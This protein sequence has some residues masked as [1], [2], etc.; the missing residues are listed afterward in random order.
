MS[1]DTLFRDM[2]EKHADGILVVDRRG[3][4]RSANPAAQALLGRAERD[5]LGQPFGYPLAPG[6]AEI[7]I[8]AEPGE[9]R[10]AEMHVAETE[11]GGQAVYLVMLRDITARKQIETQLLASQAR[12]AGIVSLSEDAIISIDDAQNI[13]LFNQGAERMFGYRANEVLGRP[14]GRLLPERYL[15]AHIDHIQKFASSHDFLRPMNQRS[16]VFGLR[17]DGAEFPAEASLSKFE[18]GG[19]K[20]MTVQLRDVSERVLAE[21]EIRAL[22]AELEQRVAARTT[23]LRGERQRIQAI[24]DTLGEGIVFTDAEGLIEYV[25]PALE[26]LTGYAASEVLGRNPRVFSSGNTPRTVYESLWLTILGGRTWRGELINC[27]KDGTL[28]DA[29]L[30]IAPLHGEDGA[31]VGFVSV[32]RDITRQ[33][34]LDRFKDQFVSNVS[35]ELRTPLANVKLYLSLL[36]RGRPDKRDQYMLTLQR[37]TQRLENLIEDLLK[38]SRFDSGV[39]LIRTLPIDLNH[40]AADLIS[41]RSAVATDQGLTLDCQPDPNLPLALADPNL[42]TQVMSNLMANA[43]RYTPRGGAISVTTAARQRD[44]Q[45]WITF[46]VQDTGPG[47]PPQDMPHL[48]DRFY[49]GE[50]GHTSGAPGAG[51]GLAICRD[52]VD[53][54][55]GSI[56]VES[57]PGQGAT[58]TVW[59]RPAREKEA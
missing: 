5:V 6:N 46:T 20:V 26:R 12:L 43:I 58:F 34:E 53:H 30:T 10:A 25:N 24:L 57:Q 3:L 22:N 9:P 14:L 52:I 45:E 15:G 27:R 59:L 36:E 51:L 49:R 29:L 16:F 56:T 2:I 39:F 23:E 48:F 38:I 21:A 11:W 1:D 19:E 31:I 54:M 35:N 28:Y 8:V 18:V 37:E 13:T 50:A 42:T 44:G 7:E 4:V 33:K 32:Q 40:L 17:K 41:D 55:H 47:I